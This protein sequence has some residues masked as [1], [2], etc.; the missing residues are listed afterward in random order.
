[1]KVESGT[2]ELL[3]A[4]HKKCVS[5]LLE[6]NQE[7]LLEEY[8][9]TGSDQPEYLVGYQDAQKINSLLISELILNCDKYYEHFKKISP[10]EIPLPQTAIYGIGEI[11]S[12]TKYINLNV[13]LFTNYCNRAVAYAKK[14]MYDKAIKDLD[15]AIELKPHE[16]YPYGIKAHIYQKSEKFEQAYLEYKNTYDRSEKSEILI[17]MSLAK[18]RANKK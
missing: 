1:M 7:K 4:F 14:E 15:K 8:K 12:L 10:T 5:N 2:N 9:T 17:F 3:E 18:R 13:N 11:D 6:D 16:A